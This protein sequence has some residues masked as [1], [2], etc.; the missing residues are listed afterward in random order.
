VDRDTATTLLPDGAALAPPHRLR[1]SLAWTLGGDGASKVAVLILNLLAARQLLPTE[2]AF[3]VGVLATSL[4]ASAF[5]DAG[6]SILVS[7]E[8]ARASAPVV[9]VLRRAL[10]LRLPT[11]PI[12]GVVL[13]LGYAI[14]ARSQSVD[15]AVL[16]VFSIASVLA[17]IEIP[18]LA[19]LRARLGF[20]DAT[21]ASAAG[22]WTTTGL[23]ALAFVAADPSDPLLVLA[24]AHVA[25]EAVSALL[26]FAFLHPA[27]PASRLG[28][29][30]PSRIALRR[31]LPYASNSVLNVAYNR[32]DVVIVA[33]LTSAGQFAAYAPASRIQDA[34]YLL[35]GSLA[36]VAVPMM[37]RLAAGRDAA[38]HM[39]ALL[40][41]LWIGG[42]ALAIPGSVILFVLMPQV[43]SL[44]L[45][46]SYAE[47]TT[48]TR[49]LMWSM[50][51]ATIGAPLLAVLIALDRGVDTTRAYAAAFMVSLVL[52]CSLDWWLGAIG[53]AIASLAR[54]VANLLVAAYYTRRALR[55][56]GARDLADTPGPQPAVDEVVA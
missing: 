54:D 9:R 30:D 15:P 18:L 35:P 32:L 42:A 40:R 20:R 48:P 36:V 29:W 14:L 3:Y 16:I 8:I 5:W 24:L 4:F 41:K 7:V 13:V 46:S 1:T 33:A 21:L 34:L 45:G 22:R 23:V 25:G 17:S 52:H 56:L 49:I 55:R 28:G 19:A 53:A 51:I 27:T 6:V 50:I 12:W 11:L 31:A 44:L 43:I 2:F 10:A 47:S 26:A 37:A 38:G 39:A